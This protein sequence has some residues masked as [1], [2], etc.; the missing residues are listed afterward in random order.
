MRSPGR[1]RRADRPM[2]APIAPSTSSRGPAWFYGGDCAGAAPQRRSHPET[3]GGGPWN[4]APAG[5]A[6]DRCPPILGPMEKITT[7]PCDLAQNQAYTR[8]EPT[9]TIG[10]RRKVSR[11]ARNWGHG[12][13]PTETVRS[14]DHRARCLRAA[15]AG[16]RGD[17]SRPAY[18]A[19]PSVTGRT[20][21]RVPGPAPGRFLLS[22]RRSCSEFP[23]ES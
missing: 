19:H 22:E 5:P 15:V 12:H 21:P 2:W 13:K 6:A 1:D 20:A 9:A 17:G 16:F 10:A 7:V 14:S 23:P 4:G 8:A 3:T 11:H 18:L